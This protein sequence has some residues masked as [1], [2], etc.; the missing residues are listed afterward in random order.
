[1][2][3][4]FS[5]ILCI[6]QR[7]CVIYLHAGNNEKS[8]LYSHHG[9]IC[10]DDFIHDDSV[11]R[12]FSHC[13][14]NCKKRFLFVY[15]FITY[16]TTLGIFIL[17]FRI[18]LHSEWRSKWVCESNL[19]ILKT[20]GVWFL[21][22]LTSYDMNP[23]MATINL[24]FYYIIFPWFTLI[25]ISC[26]IIIIK[27]VNSFCLFGFFFHW[28]KHGVS[29]TVHVPRIYSAFSFHAYFELKRLRVNVC[30]TKGIS[31]MNG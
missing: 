1:M 8:V 19:L 6:I 29:M 24:I 5:L 26:E 3:Y 30:V 4:H 27:T 21:R 16:A 25:L 11:D 12:F 15:Q 23:N 2:I 13:E 20:F 28:C 18:S 10:F 7:N 22:T 9:F 14:E 31:K 17:F